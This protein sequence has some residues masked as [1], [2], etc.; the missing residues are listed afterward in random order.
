VKKISARAALRGLALPLAIISAAFAVETAECAARN[1]A[2]AEAQ[3]EFASF[4]D[5][6]MAG[7]QKER[8]IPGMAF[9]AVR[10]G[11][12]LYLKGYGVADLASRAPVD[13]E[14]A[15]FRIGA[16]SQPVTAVAV[17]QL[18]ER[19]RVGLDED[20]NVYL[21]RWK[22]PR[23]Q[24]AAPVTARHIL[25]HTAGFGYKELETAAPTSADERAYPAKLPKIMPGRVEE[26]GLS[27]RESGMGY[28][29]LGSIVER[30]SRMNFDAAIKKHIFAPL[31]ME[32]SVFAATSADTRK[33]A[34]GYDALGQAVPYE[35][36]YDLPAYGMSTTARD[37]SRFMIAQ[38]SGGGSG[39]SRILGETHAGSMMR[40][41]FSPHPMINGAALGYLE[42]PVS[43][44]RT[45]QRDGSS[46]GFSSFLMLI[47]EKNFGLFLAANVSGVDFGDELARS[48]VERFFPAEGEGWPPPYPSSGQVAIHPGVEGYYR[49]N[50]ISLLTAEKILRM[51]SPQIRVSID[52]GRVITRLA[53]SD[54]PPVVWLPRSASGDLFWHEGG[55]YIFFPRG[56][57]GLVTSLVMG[58]AENTFDK[59]RT[60]ESYYWQRALISL[61][62]AAALVSFLGLFTGNAINKG[63]FPWESGLSSDTELWGISSLFCLVQT[64]FVIGL[65]VS[66]YTVGREFKIFVPYQVKALFVIPLAGGLLLAWLWFRTLS[67]LFSPDHHWLERVLIIA[68]AFAETG[69]M[70][71]L[72]HWRLLGFMF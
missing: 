29:L 66:E 9:A 62:A 34:A 53:G 13:P 5:G 52:G 18:A 63:R 70:F 44:I 54:E 1:N 25:T 6:F 68:V 58:G 11:E 67:K 55:G 16:I 2:K 72:A 71:F 17:M 48:V 45:L 60:F 27:Y 37:M 31:G 14:R 41:Q 40:R 46:P 49:T 20:V 8:S 10:D 21:R 61:F 56:E 42:R 51:T 30:Y 19:G 47:P 39:K 43:G 65:A 3:R 57:S 36:R 23:G 33:L 12:L 24:F 69:Y 28:A 4:I 22:I 35:Y 7:V 32:D 50:K 15:L 38:L 64:A 26:P 59:V